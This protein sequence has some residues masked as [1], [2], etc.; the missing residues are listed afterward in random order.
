MFSALPVLGFA[1]N[2]HFVFVFF[3]TMTHCWESTETVPTVLLLLVQG[4]IISK[5]YINDCF[6]RFLD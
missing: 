3:A 4:E 5:Q 2:C 6:R 1:V